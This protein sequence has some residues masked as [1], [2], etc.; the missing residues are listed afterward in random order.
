[1]KIVIDANIIISALRFGGSPR[2]ILDLANRGDVVSFTSSEVMA[3]IENVL[4]S[5][6]AVSPSEWII[7][8]GAIRDNL[9]I[10]PIPELPSVPELRDQRDLHVL[11]AAELCT[12]DFIIS[13][14]KDLLVLG[15]YKNV[16]I[17]TASDFIKQFEP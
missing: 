16:P 10:I 12:A 7:I 3:E 2:K 14:D 5:K 1:M 4:I 11:A 8:A 15:H 13:G 17:I 6:F 9:T